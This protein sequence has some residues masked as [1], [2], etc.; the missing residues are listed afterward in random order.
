MISTGKDNIMRRESYP[1]QWPD[2]WPRT[3]KAQRR[4]NLNFRTRFGEDRDEVIHR[5]N[6]RGTNVVVTANLTLNG[7]GLP[8]AN[9]RAP[10]DVGI[11]VWW[12][13]R[14][15]ERVMPCDRWSTVDANMRAICLTIEALAGIDRWGASE[16]VERAFSGFAA[17]PPPGGTATE[18]VRVPIDWRK[19]L[20]IDEAKLR[21]AMGVGFNQHLMLN[22]VKAKYR[23]MIAD[24]HPDKGGNVELAA[25]LNEA[26]AAAEGELA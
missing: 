25:L 13:E 16:M 7:S 3:P 24:A 20:E 26:M 1:L 11:A 6:K 15:R 4:R 2:H 22:M 9:V 5:L 19:A 10:E 14:G 17:L 8:A 18:E 21:E 23:A 12:I